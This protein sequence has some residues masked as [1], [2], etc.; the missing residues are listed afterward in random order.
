M[1][2]IKSGY[3]LC[4]IVRH[5]TYSVLGVLSSLLGILSLL[6][7]NLWKITKNNGMNLT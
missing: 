4:L 2:Y 6:I 1:L 7:R 3:S 5:G